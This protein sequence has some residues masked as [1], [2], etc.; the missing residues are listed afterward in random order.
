MK[1]ETVLSEPSLPLCVA[2]ATSI[3]D[4]DCILMLKKSGLT[5]KVRLMASATG[6]EFTLFRN[7]LD[8]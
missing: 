3:E 4:Q 5:R 7:A 6:S 1:L 8:P 2:V